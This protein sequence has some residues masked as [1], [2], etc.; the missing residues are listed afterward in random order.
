[1]DENKWFKRLWRANAVLILLVL[2]VGI[3][4]HSY[5]TVRGWFREPF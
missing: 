5:R 4:D 1:M 2:V 3:G